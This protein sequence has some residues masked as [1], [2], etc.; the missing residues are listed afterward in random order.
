M[1]CDFFSCRMNEMNTRKTH[2]EEKNEFT[3]CDCFS[4]RTSE[5]IV[6]CTHWDE[7]NF[8]WNCAMWFFACRTNKVNARNMDQQEKLHCV[9]FLHTE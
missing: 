3:L 9:K 8:K 2:W 6:R 4:H 5:G 1:Q 7:T